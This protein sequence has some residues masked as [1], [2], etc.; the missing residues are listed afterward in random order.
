LPSYGER[1]V[2]AIAFDRG[3][4]VTVATRLPVGLAEGGGW[5]DTTIELVSQPLVDV[6]TGRCHEGGTTSLVELLDT[7][8]VAL[9]APLPETLPEPGLPEP[10]P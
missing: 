4:A 10:G 3:G 5:G 2:H 6:I 8:P 1:S 9:L 7:Y